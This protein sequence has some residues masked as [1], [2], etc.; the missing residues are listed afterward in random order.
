[1]RNRDAV[2]DGGTPGAKGL[3]A[4]KKG[5]LV[6]ALAAFQT[7]GCSVLVGGGVDD[8]CQSD[9]DCA[10]LGFAGAVC[11]AAKSVCVPIDLPSTCQKDADCTDAA[12]PACN[13]ATKMCVAKG[14]ETAQECIDANGGKE[15]ICRA[16]KTCV[17]LTSLDCTEVFGN[18]KD[19]NAIVL[20][21]LGPLVGADA[22][23]GVP[24]HNGAKLM[25]NE[26]KDL[27]GL[28]G[29]P[30]GAKRP[31][32]MV[33]CHDLGGPE[34]D[35]NRAA[36]HLVNDVKVPAIL[37]P[38]FSG[39]LLDVAQTETIPAGVLLISGSATSPL[40]TDLD[41]KDLVWRTC[42]SDAIQA[43]PMAGLLGPLEAE[44][45][46]DPAYQGGDL[47]VAMTVKG[48]AYG[49]GLAGAVTPLLV[50]NGKT[51]SE[52]GDNFKPIGYADPNEM[53]VDYTTVITDV[54]SVKP[55]VVLLFGTTEIAVELFDGIEKAW[56]S[57][58]P[59]PPRPYY[60]VP[61]GGK[62]AELLA[63]VGDDE[64][65]RKRVRGTV[66]GVAGDLYNAFK[67]RYSTFIKEDPLAYA[68][69]GYDA[70]YLL[71]YSIL[72]IGDKPLTGANI[73]DGLK[74][75]SKGTPIDAGPTAINDAFSALQ[76]AGEIDYTGASGPLNFDTK[77]GEAKAD[78][79]IWCVGRNS[80][81]EPVFYSSGQRYDAAQ[82]KIV[83]TY[84]DQGQCD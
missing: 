81:M 20:G 29:G 21:F 26:L 11:N 75:M 64:S 52:N 54:L 55:H 60:L 42:P 35:P 67:L 39:V 50:F 16:D 31:L 13:L 6:A 82:N 18:Y 4:M 62:V 53:A 56:G 43:I 41:D 63:K 7:I 74:K 38:A 32:A 80:N 15:S 48:D 10:D 24:I 27:V 66:P 40:I 36:K 51:A 5:V 17:Q 59:T 34:N 14:C 2:R 71:A 57:L 28:P 83:G 68:E 61:D 58:N 72:A 8:S 69:T 65:R 76:S 77:T 1:M 9:T 79:D 49:K 70:A 3:A 30:G 73:A 19:P 25:L 44:I 47:R 37:G 12:L 78:I 84:N 46:A 45:K 23:T 33:F 22:S